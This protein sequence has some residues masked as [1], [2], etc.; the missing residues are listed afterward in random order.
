MYG[1]QFSSKEISPYG[2]A[3]NAHYVEYIFRPSDTSRSSTNRTRD[4]DTRREKKNILGN[5]SIVKH[6]PVRHIRAVIRGEK[7]AR[8]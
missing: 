2:N 3:E 5:S 6:V 8:G 7:D 4:K 1:F